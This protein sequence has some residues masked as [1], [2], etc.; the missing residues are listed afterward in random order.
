MRVLYRGE[1]FN[2]VIC[3]SGYQL[4][5]QHRFEYIVVTQPPELFNTH[6]SKKKKKSLK[7]LNFEFNC[8]YVGLYVCIILIINNINNKIITFSIQ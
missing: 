6:K 5:L 8:M 1:R 7:L 2:T 4:A 3:D